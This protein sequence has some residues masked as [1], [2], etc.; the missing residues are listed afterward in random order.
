MSGTLGVYLHRTAPEPVGTLRLNRIRGKLLSVFTYTDAWLQS[1]TGFALAPDLPLDS[2]PKNCEGLFSCFQDCSPDR[3]GRVLLRRRESALAAAEKRRP[4]T[5]SDADFLLGVNDRIRQGALRLSADNG[6]TF[7]TD[8]GE[9]SVPPLLSLPALLKASRNIESGAET[10]RDL[11]MLVDPGS[12]LGGAR[13][14]ACVRD[15]AGTL[16]IAKFPGRNDDRDV[17]LWEYV[18][19]RLARRAGLNTPEVRLHQAAGK[20][21]LL[22]RRFDRRGAERIPFL[23]AMSLLQSRDGEHGTYVDMA[24][25]MQGGAAA[26]TEDLHELWSRMVFN[27]CVYNVDDHLRNHGFLRGAGGWRLS[28]VYDLENSHPLEKEAL[29]HTGIVDGVHAFDFD[30]ALEAAVFFRYRK[31]EARSR[32]R[33][34]RDAV[35]CWRDEACRAGAAASEIARMKDVFGYVM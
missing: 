20:N 4:R 8:A 35:A 31:A 12:S 24:A 2:Y 30:T 19:F 5:L 3:W 7:L 26:P 21:V 9:A 27:M 1:P 15:A 33:E 10:D 17:P 29:L 11:R 28:P 25:A 6:G 23:S 14:K 22:V 34:I 18:T 13:P 32:L 16:F